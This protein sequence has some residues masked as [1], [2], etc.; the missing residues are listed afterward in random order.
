[1]RFHFD[2]VFYYV[3]DMERAIQFYTGVLGFTL[4]SRDTV[5][6]FDVDGVR[7]EV[8][9]AAG[10]SELAGTGNARLCLRVD[11]VEQALAEL[12]T[13]GVRTGAAEAKDTGALGTFQDPDGNEICLWQYYDESVKH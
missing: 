12:R 9:P 3:A 4:V 6:R 10:K 7:F 8:V 1:M 5:A 13:K 11:D 2:A